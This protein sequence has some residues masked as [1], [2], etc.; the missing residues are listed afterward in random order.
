[1]ECKSINH[2]NMHVAIHVCCLYYIFKLCNRH[3]VYMHVCMTFVYSRKYSLKCDKK[4]KNQLNKHF[5][6][7]IRKENHFLWKQHPVSCY[8]DRLRGKAG[9]GGKQHPKSLVLVFFPQ[10]A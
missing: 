3:I 9:Q 4:K 8:R 7:K 10:G 6:L 2:Q 1:M 5:L